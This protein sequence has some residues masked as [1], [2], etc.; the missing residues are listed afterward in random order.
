MSFFR[1]VACPPGEAVEE[2][3]QA[4]GETGRRPVLVPEVWPGATRPPEGADSRRR[5]E[6]LGPSPDR[7]LVAVV[8]SAL[9]PRP[10]GPRSPGASPRGDRAALSAGGG[11][12]RPRAAAWSWPW[13]SGG[14]QPRSDNP[15]TILDL[16]FVCFFHSSAPSTPTLGQPDNDFRTCACL[17]SPAAALVSY[18]SYSPPRRPPDNPPTIFGLVFFSRLSLLSRRPPPTVAPRRGGEEAAS[19]PGCPSPRRGAVVVVAVGFFT[20]S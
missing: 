14:P 13:S 19:Q 4:V 15:P 5:W 16:C 7:G 10:A 3:R 11:W 6:R 8:A 12:P 1:P 20:P 2:T 17:P 9:P 18:D